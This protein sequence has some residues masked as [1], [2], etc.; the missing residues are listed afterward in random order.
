MYILSCSWIFFAKLKGRQYYSLYTYILHQIIEI[1]KI[2]GRQYTG[3]SLSPNIRD[4]NNKWVYST[5]SEVT[6]IYHE[7]SCSLRVT[8]TKNL[9][10]HRVPCNLIDRKHHLNPFLKIKLSTIISMPPLGRPENNC[11]MFLL[12]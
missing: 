7:V 5:Y 6:V 9:S 8:C 1:A 2:K 12:K 3:T 4:A 10:S 11:E